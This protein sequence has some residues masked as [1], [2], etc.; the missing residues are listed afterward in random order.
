MTKLSGCCP[1]VLLF[2]QT[3]GKRM[4]I[5]V[6]SYGN[7]NLWKENLLRNDESKLRALMT[8]KEPETDV[9]FPKKMS[10]GCVIA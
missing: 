5:P 8:C 9:K 3:L 4:F 7:L 2:Y 1:C 10:I 6:N